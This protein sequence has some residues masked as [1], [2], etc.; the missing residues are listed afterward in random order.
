M[1]RITVICSMC[2]ELS[3]SWK[4]FKPALFILIHFEIGQKGIKKCLPYLL[5]VTLIHNKEPAAESKMDLK[6]WVLLQCLA[7]QV[8]NLIT[9]AAG[10]E[11]PG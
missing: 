5:L 2:P 7:C 6:Y 11:K 3:V 10:V 4:P 8:L 1:T 9:T